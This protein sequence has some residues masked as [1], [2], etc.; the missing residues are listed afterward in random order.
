VVFSSLSIDVNGLDKS[1]W[2]SSKQ[3]PSFE[4]PCIKGII[5]YWRFSFFTDLIIKSYDS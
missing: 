1:S 4:L 2:K 5:V 3:L